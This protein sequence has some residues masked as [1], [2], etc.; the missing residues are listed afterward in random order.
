MDKSESS[1]GIEGEH[2]LGVQ[3]LGDN[4]NPEAKKPKIGDI[5]V[6]EEG[7][8]GGIKD[9]QLHLGEVLPVPSEGVESEVPGDQNACSEAGM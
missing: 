3:S 2:L 1:P 7:E 5:S 8:N 4:L 9:T 6:R